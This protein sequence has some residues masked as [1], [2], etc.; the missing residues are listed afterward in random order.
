MQRRQ[1][2]RQL[3]RCRAGLRCCA[4]FTLIEM[5]VTIAI[6]SLLAAVLTTGMWTAQE[7]AKRA[8][9]QQALT[10]IHNE[11]MPR[12]EGYQLRRLPVD[13]IGASQV[14][15]LVAGQKRLGATRELMRMELPDDPSDLSFTPNFLKASF[16][17]GGGAAWYSPW[18]SSPA[19]GTPGIYQKEI[20]NG[21]V[22]AVQ[23]YGGSAPSMATAMQ[24]FPKSELLYLILT[25][26]ADD[27]DDVANAFSQSDV[28]DRDADGQYELRDGWGY[29][30]E[31]LR[32][33]AGFISDL[34]PMYSITA[35]DSRFVSGMQSDTNIPGNYLTRD[36]VNNHDTFDL[37]KVD[38]PAGSPPLPERGY[39]LF[40]LVF[41]G[42]GNFD[43]MLSD[44]C[45]LAIDFSGVT[46]GGGSN[47]FTSNNFSDPYMIVPIGGVSYLRASRINASADS[48]IHNQTYGAR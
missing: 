2:S 8:R 33:P 28:S 25:V 48:Y 6:I 9:T 32:W 46:G 37:L 40:P 15:P 26:G 42:G 16:G 12:W 44:Q 11:L 36:Q 13:V 41:S 30:L 45:A 17:T 20:N 31:W 3:A 23:L 47:P 18:A 34:Q 24:F 27:G 35:S 19:T 14:S 1:Y 39:N 21:L 29:P 43:V 10:K 5:L 4:G 7:S 38:P 22:R